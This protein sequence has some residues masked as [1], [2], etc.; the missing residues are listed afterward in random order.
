MPWINDGGIVKGKKLLLDSLKEHFL[1]T[2]GKIPSADSACKKHISAEEEGA[3][4]TAMIET[5][6]AG[7]MTWYFKDI[8]SAP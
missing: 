8:K 2:A 5:E 6:A 3:F 4:P 1:V 7:A